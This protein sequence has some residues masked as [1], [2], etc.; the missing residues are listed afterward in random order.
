MRNIKRF[1]IGEKNHNMNGILII[2][3]SIVTNTKPNTELLKTRI[4]HKGCPKR[5]V[6]YLERS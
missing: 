3:N 2:N 5:K 6:Q 4:S 1:R